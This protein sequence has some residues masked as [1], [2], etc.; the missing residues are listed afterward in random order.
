M[1]QRP[2][3]SCGRAVVHG[4]MAAGANLSLCFACDRP[5]SRD[6]CSRKWNHV[7]NTEHWEELGE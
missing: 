2:R 4:K 6:G 5:G 3:A 1:V 7:R